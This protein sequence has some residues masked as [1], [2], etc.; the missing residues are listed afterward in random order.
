[1]FLQYLFWKQW[2]QLKK[3][4]N[5]RGIEIIGDIPIYVSYDSADV[6][7]RP[8]LFELDEELLPTRVA[9]CPP[10]AFSADGQLWGNPIYHWEIH[11]AEKYA[12]W[13]KRIQASMKI[14][15]IVRIDHFRG[16]DSFFTIPYG[17]KTAKNGVWE[18]G[19]GHELFQH[20][21]NELG[22]LKIIAEDLGFITGSVKELL[23]KT[24]YPGMKLL[25]FGFDSREE[26]NYLHLPYEY[27]KNCVVYTGTHDNNTILGWYYECKEQDR[28]FMLEYLNINDVKELA[29]AMIRCCFASVADTVIIPMQDYL[30]IGSEGRMNTPSTIGKNWMWRMREG[31][32]SSKL[33]KYM[34]ALTRIYMR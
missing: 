1:M 26:N 17:Q 28:H 23:R 12:W 32:Y 18:E 16:F 14:Y 4:A 21:E 2:F 33:E 15:D 24:G 25:Q 10:D 20:L 31:E 19:P 8:E 3:Y 5:E 9:G 34:E 27:E 30:G 6:W 29:D 11:K 7:T 13:T 22:T